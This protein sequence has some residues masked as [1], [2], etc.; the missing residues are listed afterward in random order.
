MPEESDWFI[1]PDLFLVVA[2]LSIYATILRHSWMLRNYH[3]SKV[4]GANTG[5]IWDRQD[6]DGPYIG[7]TNF[8]I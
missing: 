5:P 8:V 4:H 7:P 3:E 6:P 1:C 2:V